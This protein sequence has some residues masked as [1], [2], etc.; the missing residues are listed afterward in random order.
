MKRTPIGKAR[1][2]LSALVK[3][4]EH[5]EWT[6]IMRRGKP[7]AVIM[8]VEDYRKIDGPSV[9]AS[10]SETAERREPPLQE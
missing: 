9:L 1:T 4:A 7:P 8:S 6:V 5:G 2:H 3:A 10:P